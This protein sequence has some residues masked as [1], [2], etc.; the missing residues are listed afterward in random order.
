VSGAKVKSNS[1]VPPP[2]FVLLEK[3][4]LKYGASALLA[5]IV[6]LKAPVSGE[7]DLSYT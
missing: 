2:V 4:K 3:P 1:A 5:A 7:Y 6:N